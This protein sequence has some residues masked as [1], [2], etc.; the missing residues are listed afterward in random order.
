VVRARVVATLATAVTL[1]A[2]S[3]ASGSSAPA[4][5]A[6]TSTT[7]AATTSTTVAGS[8]GCDAPP[9]SGRRSVTI[10]S[11]G[12]QRTFR[13]AVPPASAG[14]GP[15][16]L[17]LD[18]HGRGSN[19][20]EQAVYSDLE[21]RGTARGD[22]VL[23]PNGVSLRGTRIWNIVNRSAGL[24]DVGFTADLLAWAESHLCID[25]RQVDATGISNGAG[26]SAFLPC[27]LDGRFAAIAPVAGVNLVDVCPTG[28]PVSVLAFHGEQDPV[29]PYHGANAVAGTSIGAKPVPDAVAAWARHDSCDAQPTETRVSTHVTRT[30]YHGCRAGTDVVLDTV[31][32]GGHT[33]P[34]SKISL[35]RLGATTHEIDATGLI[36]DFF[37]AHPLRTG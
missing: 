24:D 14:T 29:V 12:R 31:A 2:C 23:S 28:T 4:P 26:M 3:G 32:D 17:I 36:L 30:T 11:R 10:D 33:W 18:F 16:P 21:A 15:R 22:V 9:P 35:P 37:A 5:S 7:A 6:P 20:V 1:A 25:T 8:P 27:Q 34:G 19:A 13:L